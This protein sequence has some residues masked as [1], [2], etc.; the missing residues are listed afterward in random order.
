M[1]ICYTVGTVSKWL[2]LFSN[3]LRI[4]VMLFREKR[5]AGPQRHA[6]FLVSDQAEKDKPCDECADADERKEHIHHRN[7]HK[8]ETG[9]ES[10]KTENSERLHRAI[11]ELADLVGLLENGIVRWRRWR[12]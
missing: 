6:A 5:C 7:S 8:A 10:T 12:V 11:L 3:V 4:L 1:Q 9:D 2:A